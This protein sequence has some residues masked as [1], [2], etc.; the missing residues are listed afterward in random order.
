MDGNFTC[1][2]GIVCSWCNGV[3]IFLIYSIIG[4]L[5]YHI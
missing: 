5:L 1:K 2:E 4:F 3:T